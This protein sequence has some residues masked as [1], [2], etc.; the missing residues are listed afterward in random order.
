MRLP[1]TGQLRVET[2]DDL[3]LSTLGQFYQRLREGRYEQLL[4]E[5]EARR[6]ETGKTLWWEDGI[7]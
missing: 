4:P 5:R 6:E 1:S 3:A 2:P 7:F